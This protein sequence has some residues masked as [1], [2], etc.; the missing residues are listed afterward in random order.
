[1]RLAITRFAVADY[2]PVFRDVLISYL[3]AS[4]DRKVVFCVSNGRDLVEKVRSSQA[5]VL[6][7]DLFLPVLSGIESIR[8]IRSFN[9]DMKILAISSVFQPDYAGLLKECDVNGYCARSIIDILDAYKRILSGKRFFDNTYFSR[10]EERENKLLNSK[11]VERL[12]EKINPTEIKIL[13]LC[14]EGMTNKEIADKLNFSTRTIDTY[15]SRLF[16]KLN[17]KSRFELMWFA[18]NNGICRLSC[19]NSD[20]GYCEMDSYFCKSFF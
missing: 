1:M 5:D 14:C 8:Q 3:C 18:Y 2:D 17:V 10:W 12:P 6:I 16:I 15:F 13:L 11:P 19:P 4:L 7:A 9:R 20:K